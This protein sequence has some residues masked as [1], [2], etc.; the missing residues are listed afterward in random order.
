MP[1]I[2]LDR[3]P[4]AGDGCGWVVQIDSLDYHPMNLSS[5]FQ[6]DSLKVNVTY[7]TDTS[8]FYF[9]LLPSVMPVININCIERR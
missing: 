9:G 5:G 2:I 8:H 1:A 7:A 6:V 3:G 4:V